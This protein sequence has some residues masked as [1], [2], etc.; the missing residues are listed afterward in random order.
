MG[1]NL[2]TAVRVCSPYP[3]VYKKVA[4]MINITDQDH[5]RHELGSLHCSQV[6]YILLDH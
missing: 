2:G 5:D 1:V 3:R 6:L 4:V